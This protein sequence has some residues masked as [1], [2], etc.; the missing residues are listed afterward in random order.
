MTAAMSS[1]MLV[2]HFAIPMPGAVMDRAHLA[3]LADLVLS[4]GILPRSRVPAS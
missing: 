1:A 2:L 3:A 4:G